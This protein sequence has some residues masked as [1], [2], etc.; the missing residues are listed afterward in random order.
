[1]FPARY[2]RCGGVS[3]SYDS[4]KARLLDSVLD[5]SDFGQIGQP[6]AGLV[7]VCE[8]HPTSEALEVRARSLSSISHEWAAFASANGGSWRSHPGHVRILRLR[9]LLRGR[10]FAFE[11]F[12]TTGPEKG[13]K[14]AQCLIS[15]QDGKITFDDGLNLLS[16]Y[17]E[18]R[19]AILAEV[20]GRLPAGRVSFGWVWSLQTIA[21]QAFFNIPGTSAHVIKHVVVHSI[22][23]SQWPCWES[24][25]RGIS[26]NVR[27]NVKRAE[28][29]D[30]PV[31]VERRKGLGAILLIGH[32]V[33]MRQLTLDRVD[34]HHASWRMALSYLSHLLVMGESCHIAIARQGKAPLA[35]LFGYESGSTFYYW[36]GGSVDSS[37]GASWK[38]L[39]ETVAFWYEQQP[40]G[41]FIMGYFDDSLTGIR[42][43]GLHRQRESLRKSDYKTEL[44]CFDWDPTKAR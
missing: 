20:L 22:D 30:P 3:L 40:K 25:Y 33:R 27:R 17:S 24:Y 1:M 44:I 12:L 29:S 19:Q 42:R 37:N 39:T 9:R 43:E 34:M 5:P 18:Y 11:A 4:E 10:L 31:I 16:G 15:V 6:D 41:Q 32:L 28:Q 7:D 23:L 21:P 38:L 13:R 36:Q 26:N 14:I 2:A 8:P 35:A